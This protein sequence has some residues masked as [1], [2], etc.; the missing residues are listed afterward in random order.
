MNTV[1][2]TCTIARETV[3]SFCGGPVNSVH[4]YWELATAIMEQTRAASTYQRN[5][6]CGSLGF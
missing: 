4:A 6:I 2:V 1:R 5:F 3:N